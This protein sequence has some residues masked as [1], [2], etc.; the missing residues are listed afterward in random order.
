MGDRH[1]IGIRTSGESTLYL[2]SHWGG[3]EQ[4]QDLASALLAAGPRWD[5]HAYAT[6]ILVSQIVGNQWDQ[7]TGFG[8]SVGEFY[9]P[10]YDHIYEVDW[11]AKLVFK[12]YLNE[13]GSKIDDYKDYTFEQFI[14]EYDRSR[15]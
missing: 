4:E 5:D 14:N 9:Q 1:V 15:G 6:R 3:E 8:L 12:I 11:D 7:E 10:D 2:Y 13:N